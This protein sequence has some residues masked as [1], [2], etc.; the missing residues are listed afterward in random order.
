MLPVGMNNMIVFVSL[1][2]TLKTFV[3]FLNFFFLYHSKKAAMSRE[4]RVKAAEVPQN[5][6]QP[7]N[8]TASSSGNASTAAPPASDNR[9]DF[10]M[11]TASLSPRVMAPVWDRRVITPRS[12]ELRASKLILR[13]LSLQV[14]NI[15]QFQMRVFYY[16]NIYSI[17][18]CRG[19]VKWRK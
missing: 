18:Y 13:T 8:T 11:E 12:M 1:T 6:Q 7:S 5:S 10:C 19:S 17:F 4:M 9:M 3:R 14:M 16:T 2:P 15:R